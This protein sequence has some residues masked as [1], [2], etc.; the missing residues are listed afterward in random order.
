MKYEFWRPIKI[1][2]DYFRLRIIIRKGTVATEQ[3]HLQIYFDSL[4]SGQ[5]S[6]FEDSDLIL[7][8]L[9]YSTS[10]PEA[11]IYIAA[12][13]KQKENPSTCFLGR[14]RTSSCVL[15]EIGLFELD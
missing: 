11:C 1:I 9:N 3:R 4:K 8:L 10:W 12:Y 5:V 15:Q 14:T 7:W 2:P 6:M 13:T